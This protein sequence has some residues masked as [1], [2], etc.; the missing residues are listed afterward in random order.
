[1]SPLGYEAK[2]GPG[3]RADRSTPKSRPSSGNVRFA[4]DSV[5]FTRRCGP[6]GRCPHLNLPLN[7]SELTADGGIVCRWHR[8]CFDLATGEI[9]NWCEGLAEDGTSPGMEGLGNISKNRRPMT[10]LPV[11]VADGEIW[12]ALA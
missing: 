5:G 10:I 2:F 4:P 9:R 11:R 12:V 6:P 3:R 8:S 1:M 7:D